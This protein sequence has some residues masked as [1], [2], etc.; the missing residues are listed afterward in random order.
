MAAA[1]SGALDHALALSQQLHRHAPEHPFVW[2]VQGLVREKQMQFAAAE[3]AYRQGLAFSPEH[4]DL[5]T[6]L[7][8]LLLTTQQWDAAQPFY[9]QLLALRPDI[10]TLH[11]L[12][13]VHKG[14]GQLETSI[15]YSRQALEKTLDA[16]LHG[17]VPDPKDP[18]HHARAHQ[19][20]LALKQ[21][22]AKLGIPFFLIA[23]T[24]LGIVRQGALLPNDK[25]MDVALPFATPRT[26]LLD[27]LKVHGFHSPEGQRV[28]DQQEPTWLFGV[29][30]LPT[31]I[32]IDLFFAQREGEHIYLG[33]DAKPTGLRWKLRRFGLTSLRFLET[34]WQVPD[35]PEQFLEDFYGPDWRTPQHY[36][37]VLRGHALT[38][39][40]R[41]VSLC[42]GYNRINDLVRR[43][44]W[45]KALAYCDQL[46]GVVGDDPLI[47]R[48]RKA[49]EEQYRLA[50]ET[51]PTPL[52]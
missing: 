30:H 16:G 37:C 31:Q 1:H 29:L 19:A 47:Q 44:H 38:P 17:L 25:D 6:Q 26:A 9:Q 15:H 14:L 46:R 24:L 35:P 33:I 21:V 52:S 39:D 3:A 40:S 5:L 42:Y 11:N 13:M 4:P 22:L 34:D 10:A 20:L 28:R 36:D 2:I 8:Q 32:S 45:K 51:P 18:M 12:G 50:Q 23:G 43:A 41:P 7:G 48:T 49:V 27:A